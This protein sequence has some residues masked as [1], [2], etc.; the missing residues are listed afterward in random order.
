MVGKVGALRKG[1]RY[2]NYWCSRALISR[3][4][5]STYNGHSAPKLEKAILEYLG[6]FSSPKLVREHLAA[7]KTKEVKSNEKELKRVRRGLSELESQFLKHLDLLK[8]EVLTEEEFTKANE[9]IRTQK[10]T[11]E[12]RKGELE[13][14]VEEQHDKASAADSLPGAIRSFLEDFQEMDV[15]VQKAH[16]Q[17]ILKAAHVYRDGRIELELRG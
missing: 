12:A 11:L 7:A 8:R 9:V 14:W 17:T 10:T 16:L 3:A 6:Q 5:C 4:H 2:R 13:D 15:R 1:K